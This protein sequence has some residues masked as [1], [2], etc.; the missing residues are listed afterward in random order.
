MYRHILV[1]LDESAGAQQAFE[2]AM[3]LA[4]LHGAAL[5]L[6][7]VEEPLPAYAADVGEV[8]ETVEELNARFRQVQQAAD[9]RRQHT[10]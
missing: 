3:E 5:T 2:R 4:R 7:S 9:S 8:A 6:L 1:G 10:T